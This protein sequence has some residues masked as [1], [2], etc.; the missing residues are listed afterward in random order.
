VQAAAH[1]LGVRPHELAVVGDIGSDVE[2]AGAAG[3]AAVLVPTPVTL[4][5]EVAA[6]PL[7]AGSLTEAVDLLLGSRP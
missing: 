5:E 2:A 7:R 4:P 6:A 1:A 3:S